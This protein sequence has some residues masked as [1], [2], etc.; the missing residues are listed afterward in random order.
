MSVWTFKTIC[1][2]WLACKSTNI[3]TIKIKAF[4]F[5]PTICSLFLLRS[6]CVVACVNEHR[7]RAPSCRIPR[8]HSNSGPQRVRHPGSI[9]VSTS[10][11]LSV[12]FRIPPQTSPLVGI[13]WKVVPRSRVQGRVYLGTYSRGGRYLSRFERGHSG[14]W[15]HFLRSER[16]FCWVWFESFS[17]LCYGVEFALMFHRWARRNARMN[18]SSPGRDGL[19]S[20]Q[21]SCV[22]RERRSWLSRR[23]RQMQTDRVHI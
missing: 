7:Q 6:D 17:V 3:Y 21:W 19:K 1:Q 8:V 2:Y 5:T 14:N 10:W 16:I 20:G 11:W 12:G 22:R 15:C 18:P 4:N 9:S 13:S 23:W